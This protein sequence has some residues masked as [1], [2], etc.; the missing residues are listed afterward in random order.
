MSGNRSHAV[1]AQRSEAKDSLWPLTEWQPFVPPVP[2]RG[3]QGFWN[4]S[5]SL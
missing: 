3:A 4:W 1:M 2:R 5:E